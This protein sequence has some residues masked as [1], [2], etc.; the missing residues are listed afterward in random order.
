MVPS[1]AYH[2]RLLIELLS[3]GE[4]DQ[5]SSVEGVDVDRSIL[6]IASTQTRLY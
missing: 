5:L 4:H 2:R 1:R 3:E 6:L